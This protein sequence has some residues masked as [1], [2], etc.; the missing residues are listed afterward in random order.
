MLKWLNGTM[1]YVFYG[2]G[3]RKTLL[4][5]NLSSSAAIRCGA[6]SERVEDVQKAFRGAD[7]LHNTPKCS[8][9]PQ[10]R[11]HPEKKYQLYR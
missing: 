9:S 1:I 8:L 2:C 5:E 7:I 4:E 11:I 10:E 3:K 6:L